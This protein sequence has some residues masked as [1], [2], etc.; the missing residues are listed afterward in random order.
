MMLKS[1]AVLLLLSASA[2][3][4]ETRTLYA[5]EA[6]WCGA[7]KEMEPVLKKLQRKGYRVVRIDTETAKGRAL[8]KKYKV[9]SLPTYIAVDSKGREQGREV[10]AVSE[11]TLLAI[12]RIVRFLIIGIIRLLL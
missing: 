9:T 10:G 1:I 6:S 4:A 12:L 3:A 8:V 5:F 7:C 2:S 11:G